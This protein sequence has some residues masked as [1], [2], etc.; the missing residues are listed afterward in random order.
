MC[1]TERLAIGLPWSR[2][3]P[4]FDVKWPLLILTG[5]NLLHEILKRKQQLILLGIAQMLLS[6]TCERILNA[7]TSNPSWSSQRLITFH[8]PGRLDSL[9]HQFN[10]D[11]LDFGVDCSWYTKSCPLVRWNED[12]TEIVGIN[13]NILFVLFQFTRECRG[14]CRF[15]SQLKTNKIKGIKQLVFLFE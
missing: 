11:S 1:V 9:N 14:G 10:I 15:V 6:V 7:Q 13:K 3:K 12:T 2:G 4:F 5:S 8:W